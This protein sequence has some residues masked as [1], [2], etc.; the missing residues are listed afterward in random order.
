MHVISY[1]DDAVLFYILLLF[2]LSSDHAVF[3]SSYSGLHVPTN[4]SD[5]DS[6]VSHPVTCADA[7]TVYLRSQC[8]GACSDVQET[9]DVQS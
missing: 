1:D 9:A 5:S 4:N 8:S 2:T 3:N 6:V 7:V